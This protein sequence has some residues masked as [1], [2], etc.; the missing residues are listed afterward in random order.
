MMN[1][2]IENLKVKLWLLFHYPYYNFLFCVQ[3]KNS[4]KL[5]IN[6]PYETV[7]YIINHHCSVSRYGDGELQIIWHYMECGNAQNFKVDTFQQYDEKLA[8]R[9]AEILSYESKGRNHII[10]IPE[11]FKNQHIHK[12]Y[13]KIFWKRFFVDECVR[14]INIFSHD[15]KYYDANFTRFYMDHTARWK[16]S[17]PLYIELLKKIWNNQDICFIEG[18]KSRLG[19][20]NDL[21]DNVK[22]VTRLLVPTTNAYSKYDEILNRVGTLPK[23][24]LYL[25]ALGA[26]ATVLAYDMANLGY[27]VVDVGHIDIEYEWMKINA[28]HKV[29]ISNKYVNEAKGGRINSN[30]V[31]ELYQSQII[32]RIQ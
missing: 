24:K 27:W 6:G 23:Q 32:G 13:T 30:Y 19:I 18:D 5:D 4:N 2:I 26:T 12:G 8:V 9:L 22:S 14:Y 11:T 29:A 15:N 25:L 28:K 31:D 10:C 21:F 16:K 17:L 3:K 1:N 20:G 7:K